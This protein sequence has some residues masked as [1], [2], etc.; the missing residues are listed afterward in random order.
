MR[1]VL[2]YPPTANHSYANAGRKRIL[3]ESARNF[4]QVVAWEVVAK[5]AKPLAGAVS[6]TIFLHP[7]DKRIRDIDNPVKPLLDALTKAGVWTDD[8]V[9]K[10]LLVEMR[11]RF[12]GGK[13]EVEIS[14]L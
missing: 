13:C 9:V 8:S 2:P 3:T 5:R 11:D 7:P 14:E 1:L 4:R 10:R 6:V 12:D